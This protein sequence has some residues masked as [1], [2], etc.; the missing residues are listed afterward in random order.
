[1]R[2][3]E[4]DM[5]T[6]GAN[7]RRLG[8][9]VEKHKIAA[10]IPENLIKSAEKSSSTSRQQHPAQATQLPPLGMPVKQAARQPVDLEQL[11]ERMG[12]IERRLQQQNRQTGNFAT[13]RELEKLKLRMQVLERSLEH[14]IGAA[15]QRE[16]RMLAA[17]DRPSL[18]IRLRQ[19]LMRLWLYELPVIAGWLERAARSW[20]H[21][22]QPKWWPRFA[23]A[24]HEAQEQARR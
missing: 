14:E 21:N 9:G 2:L 5:D 19:R 10:K 1:M 22:S 3:L 4:F 24:W 20:W 12:L 8:Q 15:R 17:L 11:Q 18:Q 7:P 23:R 16:Y 6:S 13:T